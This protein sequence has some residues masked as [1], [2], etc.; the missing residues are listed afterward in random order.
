MNA[1][2]LSVLLEASPEKVWAA[3]T[4]PEFI[5]KWFGSDPNGTVIEANMNV[6]PGGSYVITF[7]D[8][9]GTEHTCVGKYQRVNEP[10]ELSFT[11]EWK[12]E[13]GQVS[14]VSIDLVPSDGKTFMKFSHTELGA[15]SAHQYEEGWKR[16]FEKLKLALSKSE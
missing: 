12:S 5:M 14:N 4:Q 11:W 8:S 9:D 3:W 16:T 1:V 13:P 7:R 2:A 10:F 15:S 6:Q